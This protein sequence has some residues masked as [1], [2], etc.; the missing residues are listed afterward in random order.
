M[1][2]QARNLQTSA[3]TQ[4]V[5]HHEQFAGRRIDDNRHDRMLRALD[6]QPKPEFGPVPDRHFTMPVAD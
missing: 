3:S 6:I 4:H 5:G 2:V 1:H